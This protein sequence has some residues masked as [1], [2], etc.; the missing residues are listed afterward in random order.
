MSLLSAIG[1][2]L[3]NNIK[4]VN[5]NSLLGIGNL[6]FSISS[7]GVN[8]NVS[9]DASYN[10]AIGDVFV[11]AKN[12][13]YLNSDFGW[14]EIGALQYVTDLS[15]NNKSIS[16]SGGGHTLFL[17]KN[18]TVKAVGYN[19]YG[20]LGDG[21]NTAKSAP[22]QVLNVT[23]CIGVSAGTFHSLFLLA[24]GTCKA[25]G[26]SNY[27]ALGIGSFTDTNTAVVVVGLTNCVDI[28]AGNGFSLFLLSDGT[29]KACGYNTLGQLANGNAV[30]QPSIVTVITGCKGI[31]AG[32]NFSLFL[33][34]DG[35]V[36]AA[37]Y[38]GYGQL[39]DGNT[40]T[41]VSTPVTTLG[42]ANC[43]EVSAGL[44]HSLFLLSDGTVKSAGRNNYGQLGD[45]TIVDKKIVVSVSGITNCIAIA[46]GYEHSLFLLNTGKVK[47]VGRNNYGQ[48]GDGTIV[49]K[50]IPVDVLNVTDCV[51]LTQGHNYSSLF[52]EK[53]GI[54][55]SVGYNNYG[56][57]VIGSLTSQSTPIKSILTNLTT[58]TASTPDTLI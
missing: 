37:G 34:N 28:S 41:V 38:N 52:I 1:T 42:I 30:N 5:G 24:D 36:K 11:N 13:A 35:T 54:I 48:L 44:T 3:K 56:E 23:N 39:G 29:V 33:M 55:K 40:A 12:V 46:A 43:V 50:K 15:G 16:C 6:N 14:I 57:L 58:Y 51:T 25:V 26:R 9:T 19:T 21:T 20:T 31:A 49:D 17:M 8:I 18:G 2:S 45:G 27:G 47:S 32:S 53:N 22:V 7:G 10:Y 4:T